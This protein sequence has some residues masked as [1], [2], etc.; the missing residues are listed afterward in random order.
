MFLGTNNTWVG[1]RQSVLCLPRE[2]IGFSFPIPVWFETS[3]ILI[4]RLASLV[5]AVKVKCVTW[6]PVRAIIFIIFYNGF[7]YDVDYLIIF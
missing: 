3:T 7:V 6:Q 5:Q 2:P 1:I 4:H